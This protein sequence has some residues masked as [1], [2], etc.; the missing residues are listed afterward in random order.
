MMTRMDELRM[1]VGTAA[2]C[3]AVALRTACAADGLCGFVDPF[4]GTEGNGHTHPGAAAP[5][6]MVQAGPDTG[7]GTWAYCSG[8]RFGDRTTRGFSQTHLS[9]TGCPDLG[10]VLLLPFV[11]E[12]E[13]ERPS[14]AFVPGTQ[15]ASPGFY[16]CA[17][18]GGVRVSV[19]ATERVACYRFAFPADVP[20]KVLVDTQ[21]GITWKESGEFNHV[22]VS[23]VAPE[24][25]GR[26]ISG[27]NR[28]QN[29]VNR[30]LF[31]TV[32]CARPWKALMRLAPRRGEEKAPRYVLDFGADAKGAVV[33]MKVA[34]SSVS[35]DGAKASV[36]AEA[37]GW[38]FDAVARAT[39]AKWEK[40]LSRVAVEGDEGRKRSF[41]TALYHLFVQP[42]DIADRDGRYRG[43]DN[44]VRTS[45]T[46]AYYSTLSTWDTFRAAHPLYT[47]LTPERVPGFMETIVRH[48][49]AAG[50][51]PIWTLWGKDNQCMIGTHSIPILLDA[52]QKGF[53]APGVGDDRI[54]KALEETLRR[55]TSGRRKANFDHINRYGWIPFDLE[56][57]E[58]VSRLLELGFDDWCAA[59]FFAQTGRGA[60]AAF[61]DARARCWTNVF[62]RTTGFMRGRD[63]SGAWRE[64]FNPYAL[65]TGGNSGNDFTEGN[66]WQYSWHVLQDP[67]GLVAA[68][69]GKAKFGERL[70]QLFVQP[71][72]AEG[73][74]RVH[75]V[76]G[77][78][79]Q[80]AHGNEPSHHV[81]YLFQYAGRPDLTARY[82][83]EVFDTQ[84][85]TGADGLCGNDDCGQMSAWYVFSALGF[86]PVNPCGGTY[87]LGAP[88]LPK[89]TLRCQPQPSTLTSFTVVARGLSEENKYVK[90]VTLNGKKLDRFVITHDEILAGG[91]LV[92]EMD[93]DTVIQ[94]GRR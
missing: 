25:D 39:S 45:G 36:A 87:V 63:T 29:W 84:Y 35:V 79:G 94:F 14:V 12:L 70:Q 73:M 69:G 4:I 59:R 7:N 91:E 3:A 92:F 76:S 13:G 52:W 19:T 57:G 15:R 5:F 60:E 34:L 9:G 56:K 85:R 18:A 40:L 48:H 88:Q 37:P 54:A 43:A 67:E 86:Y 83:R 11:G 62:D 42:N 58:S 51:L 23:E 90:S 6:G 28:V 21:W 65:G 89:V 71:P 49:E 20:A 33:E 44:E 53:R 66:A 24:A 78:I 32:A 17:L 68:M 47:I 82:V 74:G 64:P 27:H 75:D 41:Y 77:L 31:F 80:Y 16:G 61:Y 55:N 72:D 1:A 93:A 22:Q 8:Y 50:F 38:D 26:T 46:G 30:E 81:I 2:V 10:D